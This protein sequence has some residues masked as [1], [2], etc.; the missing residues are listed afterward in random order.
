MKPF[1]KSPREDSAQTNKRY[2]R[3][4]AEDA[5]VLTVFRLRELSCVGLDPRNAAWMH[6]FHVLK[7]VRLFN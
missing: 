1:D 4:V 2:P 6:Y 3:R 5:K 7:H